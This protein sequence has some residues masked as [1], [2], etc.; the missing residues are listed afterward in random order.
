MA[1]KRRK[2][3]RSNSKITFYRIVVYACVL[4]AVSLVIAEVSVVTTGTNVLGINTFLAR[5]P[6]SSQG[7]SGEVR[8]ENSR[9]GG[10]EIGQLDNQTRVGQGESRGTSPGQVRKLDRL[11]AEALNEEIEDVL[12]DEDAQVASDGGGFIVKRHLGARSHFPLSI[13]PETNELIVTTPAGTK[14]VTTLPDTAVHNML[15]KGILS[16]IGGGIASSSGDLGGDDED[17]GDE[18]ATDSGVIVGVNSEGETVSVNEGEGDIQLTEE[19]GQL[20]YKIKGSLKQKFVGVVPI[21]LERVVNVSAETG[22]VVSI[23]ESFFTS[24]LNFFSI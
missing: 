11:E 5:G 20:V 4:I 8:A 21:D 1:K 16:K 14:I 22:E 23:Q 15:T 7:Q 18:E 17:E 2:P 9:R 6:G 24:M 10:P 3:S 13:N 19:D 12:D